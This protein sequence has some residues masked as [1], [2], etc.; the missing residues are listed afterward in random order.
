MQDIDKFGFNL[1]NLA[2]KENYPWASPEAA[3]ESVMDMT[4][5][6]FIIST[7]A[8]VLDYEEGTEGVWQSIKD[9]GNWIKNLISRFWNWLTGADKKV[10]KEVKETDASLEKLE[11]DLKNRK[12][13]KNKK[14]GKPNKPGDTTKNKPSTTTSDTS[15]SQSQNTD[16]T[17]SSEEDKTPNSYDVPNLN[18]LNELNKLMYDARGSLSSIRKFLKRSKN[19]DTFVQKET[20]D[21]HYNLSDGIMHEL[22]NIQIVLKSNRNKFSTSKNIQSFPYDE[23]ME[24]IKYQRDLIKKLYRML[25]LDIVDATEEIKKTLESYPGVTEETKGTDAFKRVM[26]LLTT[27]IPSLVKQ[28]RIS[29][30]VIR[31][32]VKTCTTKLGGA[33]ESEDITYD[34]LIDTENNIG[35]ESLYGFTLPKSVTSAYVYDGLEEEYQVIKKLLSEC[36]AEAN[37][38]FDDYVF[39]GTEGFVDTVKLY[40]HKIWDAIRRFFMWI[41]SKFSDKYKEK[42]EIEKLRA[43]LNS[44]VKDYANYIRY[45]DHHKKSSGNESLNYELDLFGITSGLESAPSSITVTDYDAMNKSIE[46]IAENS[47][48][49]ARFTKYFIDMVSTGKANAKD[50]KKF[51]TPNLISLPSKLNQVKFPGTKTITPDDIQSFRDEVNTSLD[52]CKEFKSIIDYMNKH[53]AKIDRFFENPELKDNTLAKSMIA[54]MNRYFVP[55][56]KSISNILD[57]YVRCINTDIRKISDATR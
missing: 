31:Q 50:F 24:K 19:W 5:E 21:E 39:F 52:Y 9:F 13:N 8:I 12:N 28:F 6:E 51:I 45:D 18:Y 43:K 10:E 40:S 4:P 11:K 32:L 20:I 46:D 14:S 26:V 57:W 41:A 17:Q 44:A 16:T 3:I 27:T 2:K 47:K 33:G 35:L 53:K 1:V 30:K 38:Y 15:S 49:L 54:A 34:D 23:A 29:L 56:V 42:Y 25:K 37:E 7:R 36:D 48:D 22:N 55:S